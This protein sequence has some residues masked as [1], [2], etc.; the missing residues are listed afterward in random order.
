LALGADSFFTITIITDKKD[1]HLF[2]SNKV[3]LEGLGE[4]ERDQR[5]ILQY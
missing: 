2:W 5:N 3:P 1:Q 4:I